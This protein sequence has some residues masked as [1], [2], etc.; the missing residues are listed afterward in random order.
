MNDQMARSGVL[1]L[2][3][4]RYAVGLFWQTAE[5]PS[6]VRREAEEAARQEEVPADFYCVR[7]GY[8]TQFGLGWENSGHQQSMASAAAALAGDLAGNWLGVFRT[9]QGW[10]FVAARRDAIL[11][12]GDQLYQNEAEP[13]ARFEQEFARGGW[14]KVFT[15]AEWELGGDQTPVGDLIGAATTETRLRSLKSTLASMSSSVA[16]GGSTKTLMMILLVLLVAAGG[17][18]TY[19]TYFKPADTVV[20]P[21]NVSGQ[22]AQVVIPPKRNEDWHYYP[23]TSAL[24][25]ACERE[26][27]SFARILMGW[28][29]D[30]ISCTFVPPRFNT[31]TPQSPQSGF[32]R[33]VISEAGLRI[34]LQW[35]RDGGTLDQA[36][37]VLEAVRVR[38]RP[39][40]GGDVL[41][42][43]NEFA[44]SADDRRNP[45]LDEEAADAAR[46]I[47]QPDIEYFIWNNMQALGKGQYNLQFGSAPFVNPDEASRGLPPQEADPATLQFESALSPTTW[48][49][50]FDRIPGAWMEFARLD[51]EQKVWT[52][53][54]RIK[55][56]TEAV[57][58]WLRQRE[59]IL[60]SQSTAPGGGTPSPGQA[61]GR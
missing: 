5:E 13:R 59:T 54:F 22:Q 31:G 58:A 48:G 61:P 56:R 17:Y 46:D 24:A 2:G 16:S 14:D 52:Y 19:D 40:D 32:D 41:T 23:T 51:Y 50:L 15:P 37:N 20:A 53:T 36:F 21:P 6:Q 45:D 18:W 55:T 39:S 1:E 60:Q 44:F 43:S 7:E 26:I 38:A 57:D 3:D 29:I 12:D 27:S 4:Q 42:A 11:P 25:E 30:S 33:G 34:L 28:N 35:E 8:V 47:Y 9:D 10:W 49:P